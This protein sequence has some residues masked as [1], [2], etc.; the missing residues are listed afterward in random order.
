MKKILTFGIITL[1]LCLGVIALEREP[2]PEEPL[3]IV[4]GMPN[5][6]SVYCEQQGHILVTRENEL[7][8]YGVCIDWKCN[9]CGQWDYYRGE[10]EL[11]KAHPW[12][13]CSSL[14]LLRNKLPRRRR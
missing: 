2:I 12:K 13:T 7:G 11:K 4:I 10:C 3:D 5:P 9:E 14:N 1:F 8:Q 6:A